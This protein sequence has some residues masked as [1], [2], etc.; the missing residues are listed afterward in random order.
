MSAVAQMIL[1][2]GMA[3]LF[4]SAFAQTTTGSIA[5]TITDISQ[6]VV[7]K[8]SVKATNVSTGVSVSTVSSGSGQYEFLSLPAGRYLITVS[9]EG[10]ETSQLTDISLNV[11]QR[12]PW[13]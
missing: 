1:I 7:P 8:A 10:F 12:S 5:G 11:D 3:G 4:T 9:H 6:A 13:M 2:L